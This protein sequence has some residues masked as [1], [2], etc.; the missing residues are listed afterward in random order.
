M[1][2]AIITIFFMP[3]RA[4]SLFSADY[5]IAAASISSYITL[6]HTLRLPITPPPRHVIIDYAGQLA[7]FFDA[8][9]RHAERRAA[10]PQHARHRYCFRGVYCR[11][12]SLSPIAYRFSMIFLQLLL[13]R[14]AS[15]R[16]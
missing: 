10:P 16:F 5:A 13:F 11:H 9:A 14:Q 15:F 12:V 2:F 4:T 7:I 1:I 8:A 3:P 6:M